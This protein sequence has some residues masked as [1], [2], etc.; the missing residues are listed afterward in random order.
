M[1]HAEQALEA[2]ETTGT[3]ELRCLRWGGPYVF[4][5]FGSSAYVIRCESGDLSFTSRGL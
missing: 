4:E 1:L 3:T 2:M 5:D